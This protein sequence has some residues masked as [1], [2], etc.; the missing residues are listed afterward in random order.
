M[1]GGQRKREGGRAGETTFT[2]CCSGVIILSCSACSSGD[3]AFHALTS[4]FVIQKSLISRSVDGS[5]PRLAHV[6][7]KVFC[8]TERGANRFAKHAMSKKQG[9][10]LT[11]EMHQ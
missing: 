1:D 6:Q 4:A 8:I 9:R 3:K 7:C 5:E 10:C 2:S 11:E